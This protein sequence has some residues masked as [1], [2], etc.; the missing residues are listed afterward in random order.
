MFVLSANLARAKMYVFMSLTKH[1]TLIITTLHIYRQWTIN[2]FL[3]ET[4]IKVF[5]NKINIEHTTECTYETEVNNTQPFIGTI[6]KHTDED[7]KLNVYRKST[8]NN[9]KFLLAQP[10]KTSHYKYRLLVKKLYLS[11]FISRS[12]IH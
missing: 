3:I 6:S 5:G 4:L 11:V 7:V 2:I 10:I 9:H 1:F 12:K 8:K